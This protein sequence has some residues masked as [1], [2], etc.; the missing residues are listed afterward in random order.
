MQVLLVSLAVIAFLAIVLEEVI[1]VNKAKTTLF[2]GTLSWILLFLFP[3]HG[4]SRDEI[5][6]ALNENL[7]EI[8]TLWLF[9]M[10]AMTFVAY[11]NHQGLIESMIY[12]LLPA[13]ISEKS[14]LFLVAVFSFVF[15]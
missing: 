15:S 1:H 10:A 4:L 6:L 12:K 13:R 3:Q 14:L 8:A 7:L 5:Q 2:L 9:L 11:L